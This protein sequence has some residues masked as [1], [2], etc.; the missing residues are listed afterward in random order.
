MIGVT[1]QKKYTGE[2]LLDISISHNCIAEFVVGAGFA[3][4]FHWQTA[5]GNNNS[6]SRS[7]L[8]LQKSLF[9]PFC[10]RGRL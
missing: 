2:T 3:R 9:N 7:F 5:L 1:C 4:M 10:E 8:P 6:H